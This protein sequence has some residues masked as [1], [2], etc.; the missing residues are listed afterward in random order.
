MSQSVTEDLDRSFAGAVDVW[1]DLRGKRIFLTGGTGFFGCWFLEAISWANRSYHLGLSATVLSRDPDKFRGKN[2]VLASNP[3]FQF[4][5][6]DVRSFEFPSGNYSHFIHAATNPNALATDAARL[7]LLEEIVEGTKHC[8]EFARTCGA[9]RFLF[10]GSGAVYGR[11]PADLLR[12]PE[13]FAGGP[14]PLSPDSVYAE[15]KRVAEL[16]CVLSAS[17]AFAV[18]IARCFAFVGP[19]MTLDGHFAIGNFI[20][21]QMKGGPIRVQGDGRS[22]R[23]YMYASDLMRWLWTILMRGTGGRAYNVGS[24]VGVTIA[25]LAETVAGALKPRVQVEIAGNKD[26][27]GAQRYVPCTE[28]SR[29]ELGLC[30]RFSLQEAV[31]RTRAWFQRT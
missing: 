2:P 1:E 31:Q 4:V 24:D 30:C 13:T 21:D 16:L 12:M 22:V 3:A 27:A 15:G 6:G 28:R 17:A 23:S 26:A 9:S 5:K 25:E 14:D 11:Q 20:R 7:N 19:Y 18:T 8:L 29:Q 10:V